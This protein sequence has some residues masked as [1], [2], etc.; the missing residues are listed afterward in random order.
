[1]IPFS[2]RPGPRRGPGALPSGDPRVAA[3]LEHLR[4]GRFEEAAP[5]FEAAFAAAANPRPQLAWLAAEARTAAGLKHFHAADLP[6]ARGELERGLALCPRHPGAGEYLARIHHRSGLPGAALAALEC[7]A[8]APAGIETQLLRASCLDQMGET[9]A[10]ERALDRALALGLERPL[11]EIAEPPGPESP[12]SRRAPEAHLE[13]PGYADHRCRLAVRLMPRWPREAAAHL[14]AAL[15]INPR[16]LRARIALALI[17]LQLGR[18][19]RSLELLERARELEPGYPDVLA[20]LGLARLRS[21]DARGAISTLERAACM[22][23]EFGRAHRFLALVRH[24]LGDE[25]EALEEARRGL[26]RE[27]DVPVLPRS[28]RVPGLE[29]EGSREDDLHRAVAIRPDS[30]DLHLALGR[31]RGQRGALHEA[32]HA[33]HAALAL[34]PDYAAAQ[35]ELARIELSL[36]RASVAETLLARVTLGKPGWVDALALLGRTRLLMGRARDAV[37]PLR[38]ALRQRPALEAARADMAWALQALGPGVRARP[39][40][41]EPS[42]SGA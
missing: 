21:G 26:V 27:R 20:W 12:E 31:H 24:A 28:V 32:R 16:Y 42:T 23:R 17:C 22:R 34:E 29:A 3:G 5:L 4:R 35:L 10:A 37:L 11:G 36:G 38:A 40:W 33:F 18:V 39:A 14:E 8:G 25:R 30:P 6:R 1:L 19:P 7:A 2:L 13:A 15:E 41:W 9:S